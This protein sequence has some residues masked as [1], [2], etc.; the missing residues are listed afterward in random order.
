VSTEAR[1]CFDNMAHISGSTVASHDQSGTDYLIDNMTT[2]KWRPANTAP[3]IRYSGLFTDVDYIGLAGVN[4]SSAG[5]SLVVKDSL[6]STIASFS[7]LS[8]NQPA[9]AIV[10]KTTQTVIFFEFTCTQT[11]LE[12][13]EIYFGQSIILPKKVSVG[14]KPGRWGNNDIVTTGKTEKNNPTGSTIRARGMTEVFSLNF[15]DI[16]FMEGVFKTFI[17]SAQGLAIF[18]IWDTL[19]ED[20]AIYGMWEVS[21]P[22]FVNSVSSSISMTI[23]GDAGVIIDNTLSG[24]EGG[25][26]GG[27]R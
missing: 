19:Q 4:W 21:D 25:N 27:F 14:Y 5:C 3:T 26:T 13:G 20:H 11:T 7:G 6:G 2:I 9:L 10:T 16:T 17:K 18:F 24:S 1:I 22:A 23:K 12:I 15:L 8:D